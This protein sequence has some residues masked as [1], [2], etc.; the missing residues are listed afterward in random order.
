MWT[1]AAE[2]QFLS[3]AACD[4]DVLMVAHVTGIDAQ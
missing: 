1:F 3:G 2:A 4:D